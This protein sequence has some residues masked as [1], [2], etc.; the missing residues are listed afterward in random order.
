MDNDNLNLMDT[1][2][3]YIKSQDAFPV[4]FE[5]FWQWCGYSSKQKAE[6]MLHKNFAES[7]DFNFNLKVKVQQ[8]GK[9][10]VKRNIKTYRL[11]IDCAKSFAMLAQTE[12]GREV[13]LYFL[14]CEKQLQ[15]LTSK[16]G[17]LEILRES[18]QTLIDH[19]ERITD[20]EQERERARDYLEQVNQDPAEA[21]FVD[22]RRALDHI[23]KSYSL[24]NGVEPE[25]V[26]ATFYRQFS[27]RYQM[28]LYHLAGKADKTPIA[29]LESRGYIVQAYELAKELFTK[30][31]K[32][33]NT[34][35]KGKK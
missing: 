35:K 11:S 8:E 17:K 20:L 27:L 4:D 33:G 10:S 1:I 23:I 2:T 32:S 13:R 29:Y 21:L 7:T 9:R 31:K 28:Q 26:Y 15:A 14:E 18:V 16:K 24:A 19:E 22:T 34:K 25:V 5:A 30:S 12:K 6:Q 3:E